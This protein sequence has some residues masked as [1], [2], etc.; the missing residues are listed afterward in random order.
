MLYIY[1]RKKS[2]DFRDGFIQLKNDINEAILDS[3]ANEF[4][5]ERSDLSIEEI[6][7]FEAKIMYKGKIFNTDD[8]V[9]NVDLDEEGSI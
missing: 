4:K 1:L 8:H 2:I 7:D 5:L 6:G 3:I 9:K